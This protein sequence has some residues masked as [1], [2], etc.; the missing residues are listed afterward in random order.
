M[1]G[2][3]YTQTMV[4]LASLPTSVTIDNASGSELMLHHGR[5]R[6]AV[7]ET[8]RVVTLDGR[9]DGEKTDI[10]RALKN[11][12][13]QGLITSATVFDPIDD[14]VESGHTTHGGQDSLGAVVSE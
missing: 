10:W 5:L 6:L 2:L 12:K 3:E 1:L 7:G 9:G 13:A 11:A 8:G 14:P 4:A